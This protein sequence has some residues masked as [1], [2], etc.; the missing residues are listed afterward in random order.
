MRK[1]KINREGAYQKETE[2][3]IEIVLRIIKRRR[4]EKRNRL[5]MYNFLNMPFL[6]VFC[7]YRGINLGVHNK[8]EGNLEIKNTL[9]QFWVPGHF[10]RLQNIVASLVLK[11]YILF[12]FL[13]LS[14]NDFVLMYLEITILYICN[15]LILY[16]HLFGVFFI[17][18]T[19][20][21]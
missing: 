1:S 19:M 13:F 10:G 11:K 20:A 18:Y 15:F 9:F 17:P 21:S 14:V 8:A 4:R 3:E 12:L 6:Y 2:K 16:G 5:A 7:G